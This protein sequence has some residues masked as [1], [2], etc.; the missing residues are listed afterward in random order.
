MTRHVFVRW[1]HEARP[2]VWQAPGG[3]GINLVGA[4]LDQT[5]EAL[6]SPTTQNRRHA[7]SSATA[8]SNHPA[9]RIF[10]ALLPHFGHWPNHSPGLN[11]SLCGATVFVQSHASHSKVKGLDLIGI[12]TLLGTCSHSLPSVLS[13]AGIRLLDL[14]VERAAYSAVMARNAFKVL[15]HL[16]DHLA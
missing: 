15:G 14:L 16:R 2:A 8:P 5:G 7:K 1:F 12:S 11:A 3:Q 13:T 10:N 9:V 6:T 4:L